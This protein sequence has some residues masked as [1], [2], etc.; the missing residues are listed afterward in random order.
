MSN[1]TNI[2][3]CDGKYTFV[4]DEHM[5][6]FGILRHGEPWSDEPPYNLKYGRAIS[7][8]ASELHEAREAL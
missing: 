6:V 5:S 8:L 7:A 1:T 2:S 4:C 3:V